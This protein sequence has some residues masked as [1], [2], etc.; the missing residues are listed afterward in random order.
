MHDLQTLTRLNNQ[1][2]HDNNKFAV[3]CPVQVQS[4]DGE[5]VVLET[6]EV[7]VNDPQLNILQACG[8][9]FNKNTGHSTDVRVTVELVVAIGGDSDPDFAA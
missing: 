4:L 3:G 9:T 7:E 5:E 8:I 6:G 1:K 2:L